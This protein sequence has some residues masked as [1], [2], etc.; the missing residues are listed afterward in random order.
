[1]AL[2]T[3]TVHG[4]DYEMACDDGQEDHLRKLA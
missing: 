3:L 4:H 1:M 2:I